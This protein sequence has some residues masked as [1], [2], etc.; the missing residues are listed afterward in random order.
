MVGE[1]SQDGRRGNHSCGRGGVVVS[2]NRGWVLV[3]IGRGPGE[4]EKRGDWMLELTSR[5]QS[6]NT[7][8]LLESVLE[9]GV[10][11]RAEGR[12]ESRDQSR[13]K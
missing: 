3:T 9:E 1:N 4:Q 11:S 13:S 10:K 8:P 2:R 6:R 5:T 7:N 12:G